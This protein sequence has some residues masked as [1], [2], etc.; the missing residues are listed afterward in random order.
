M[1]KPL[2]G[3][4]LFSAR[5][6][7]SEGANKTIFCYK[8]VRVIGN[9]ARN[10][11]KIARNM[12]KLITSLFIILLLTGCNTTGKKKFDPS[13]NENARNILSASFYCSILQLRGFL[14]GVSADQRG[15]IDMLSTPE[16]K[17]KADYP[18]QIMLRMQIDDEPT[19]GYWYIVKK[20]SPQ[21]LWYLAKAWKG[22]STGRIVISNLSLPTD[23]Q[24]LLA[25]DELKYMAQ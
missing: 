14:P 16:R 17:A 12:S 21:A 10:M 18:W 9:N 8:P 20:A 11:P 23:K 7:K 6:R 2:K 5:I 15:K 25:N 1:S 24:Q 4:I 19:V 3:A 22:D 13:N